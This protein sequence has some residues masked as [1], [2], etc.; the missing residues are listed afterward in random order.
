MMGY[1]YEKSSTEEMM[2]CV[3]VWCILVDAFH[4]EDQEY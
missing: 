4:V 1:E 2:S 3:H